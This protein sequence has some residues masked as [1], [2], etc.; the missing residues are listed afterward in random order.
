[1]MGLITRSNVSILVL[2]DVS[3]EED[4]RTQVLLD[5]KVSILVLVDVSPEE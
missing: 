3:P 4:Y 2:V 1:M 5:S